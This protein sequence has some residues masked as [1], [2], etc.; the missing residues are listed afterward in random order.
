MKKISLF[1]IYSMFAIVIS[2]LMLCFV[3]SITLFAETH[4]IKGDC[5]DKGNNKI[6]G[7]QCEKTEYIE[8]I[9]NNPIYTNLGLIIT[10]ILIILGPVV[11]YFDRDL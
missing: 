7:I 8:P 6:I 11:I 3:T 2:L 4:T 5:F 9:F 1:D 10:F